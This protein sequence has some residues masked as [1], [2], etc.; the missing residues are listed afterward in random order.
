[1]KPMLH[2]LV[3][4]LDVWGHGP[5]EHEK[6]DCDGNCDGYTVN[7]LHHVGE[8]NVN[9]ETKVYNKGKAGEFSSVEAPELNLFWAL[10]DGGYL[11]CSMSDIQFEYGENEIFID[12]KADGRPLLQLQTEEQAA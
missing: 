11:N 12:R 5:D 4:S 3:V 2:Y 6:Y 9:A 10:K 1:M 8:I 7:D